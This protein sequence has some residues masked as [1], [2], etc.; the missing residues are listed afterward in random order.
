MTRYLTYDV[1]TDRAFGGNPLA[2]VPEADPLPEEQLQK[3]AREFNYSETVFLYRPRRSGTPRGSGFS[4]RRW[5][6]LLQGIPPSARLWRS[7]R[8]AMGRSCG[9][10]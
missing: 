1:F 4:R 6:C 10:S 3:I 8:W 2:V 9:W 5:K 7:L